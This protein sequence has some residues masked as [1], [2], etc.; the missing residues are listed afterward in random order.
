MKFR[1]RPAALVELDEAVGRHVRQFV[2]KRFR[3]IVVTAF[4]DRAC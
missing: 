4:G 2:T 1:P 3:Y